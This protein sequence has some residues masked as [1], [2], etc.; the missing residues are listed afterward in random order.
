M[1]N[2]IAGG[3]FKWILQATASG[4]SGNKFSGFW[5]FLFRKKYCILG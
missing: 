4:V 5:G 2:P 3:N 1:Q